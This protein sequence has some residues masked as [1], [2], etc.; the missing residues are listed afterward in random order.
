MSTAAVLAN[1]GT[2]IVVCLFSLFFML[3]SG[4]TIWRW[5]LGG[6]SRRPRG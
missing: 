4:P 6:C 1:I 3:S 2:G 5:L